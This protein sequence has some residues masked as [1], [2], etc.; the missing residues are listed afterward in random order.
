MRTV[1]RGQGGDELRSHPPPSDAPGRRVG[2]SAVLVLEAGPELSDPRVNSNVS[3]LSPS[4]DQ[5]LCG[6]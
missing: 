6:P 4:Y 1:W 2:P 3:F 5:N